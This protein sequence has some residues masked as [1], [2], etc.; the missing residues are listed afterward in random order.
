M[1]RCRIC[2]ANDEEALGEGVARA[3]WKTHETRDPYSDWQAWKRAGSYWQRIM[4]DVA[5][6]TIAVLRKEHQP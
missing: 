5:V 4:R 2:T 3:M 1:S 6:P